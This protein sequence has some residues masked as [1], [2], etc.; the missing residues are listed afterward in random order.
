MQLNGRK[1][2]I[3]RGEKQAKSFA[4]LVQEKGGVPRIIPL[5][6][7]EIAPSTK[8]V[9]E[10]L[11]N[12]NK[13]DWVIFTSANGVSAFFH[14]VEKLDITLNHHVNIAVVGK[15]TNKA[16]EKYGF[17]ASLFPETFDA[18]HLAEKLIKNSST[19][20]KIS[21]IKGNLSRPYLV[22]TLKENGHLVSELTL[23]ETT[24]KDDQ[25]EKLLDC[26]KNDS[27]VFITLTSPSAVHAFMR[28]MLRKAFFVNVIFVCIG[29]ITKDAL[30]GYGQYPLLMPSQY[31][32]EGMVEIMC[33]YLK[34]D[35][36]LWKNSQDIA[37]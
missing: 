17:E 30:L 16:L 25:T 11:E 2:I 8:R 20:K 1:V 13:Q 36:N 7:F 3:T 4:K 6:E 5:L 24:I 27:P 10:Q 18:K 15:K 23:Y 9:Q 37:D 28:S 35:V 32:V 31:S 12:I 14:H 21:V 26:I 22:E 33:L 34:G 29:P 19:P